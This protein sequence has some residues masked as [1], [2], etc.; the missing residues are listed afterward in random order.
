MRQ[1]WEMGED[2]GKVDPALKKAAGEVPAAAQAAPAVQSAAD[3]EKK[4]TTW[5]EQKEI[6]KEASLPLSI[7]NSPEFAAGEWVADGLIKIGKFVFN[8]F[9]EEGQEKL[10]K[11]LDSLG[12]E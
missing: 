9:S 3:V 1:P 7:T 10:Q 6:L 5:E 8:I 2:E 12:K 11:Q 4:A